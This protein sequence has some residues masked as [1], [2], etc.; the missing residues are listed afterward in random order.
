[1]KYTFI[2]TITL[3][4]SFEFI[5]ESANNNELASNLIFNTPPG[6]PKEAKG[7][8]A[9][10][11]GENNESK[12][13][14]DIY[15]QF[16]HIKIQNE[17]NT[18]YSEELAS[19]GYGFLYVSIYDRAL[20]WKRVDAK[21]TA[22]GLLFFVDT[23]SSNKRLLRCLYSLDK[24]LGSLKRVCSSVFDK[25]GPQSLILPELTENIEHYTRSIGFFKCIPKTFSDLNQQTELI[26][27]MDGDRWDE[28]KEEMKDLGE[29]SNEDSNGDDG[30]EFNP[31]LGCKKKPFIDNW[32]TICPGDWSPFP[33]N[34]ERSGQ[35]IAPK[36]IVKGPGDTKKTGKIEFA[37]LWTYT[38]NAEDKYNIEGIPIKAVQTRYY[39]QCHKERYA[40][41]EMHYFSDIEAKKKITKV[42]KYPVKEWEPITQ[43][44]DMNIILLCERDDLY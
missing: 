7:T 22:T 44:S 8:G 13:E 31:D 40:I 3:L 2:L 41:I 15:N 35:Y 34:D 37:Y 14:L 39:A 29:E 20:G 5:A 38:Y 16:K 12:D 21:I 10:C 42:I 28:Y 18:K 36:S 26:K 32:N 6:F 30:Y 27:K 23:F 33:S 24:S 11:E 19:P 25:S 43:D 17:V 1:M 4:V 9:F